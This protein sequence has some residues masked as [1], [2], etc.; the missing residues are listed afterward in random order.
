MG[1]VRFCTHLA[2]AG[3]PAKAIQVLA[4]HA[5]ITTTERYMH[6]GPDATR[7]AIEGLRR[8]DDWRHTG[9]ARSSVIQ[10]Q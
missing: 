4:G 1:R 7:E 9:D 10:L 5:S 3:K 6:L 2:M 8:P